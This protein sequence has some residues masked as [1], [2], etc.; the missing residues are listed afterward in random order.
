MS[1]KIIIF[2]MFIFLIGGLVSW[3]LEPEFAD[4]QLAYKQYYPSPLGVY[5]DIYVQGPV[6]G[7]GA[8]AVYS[9]HLVLG[10]RP[11]SAALQKYVFFTPTMRVQGLMELSSTG[12]VFE[13][14]HGHGGNDN[15]AYMTGNLMLCAG[16]NADQE[17]GGPA[18]GLDTVGAPMI[19]FDGVYNNAI[20]SGIRAA[21]DANVI[22]AVETVP[23][24]N[25]PYVGNVFRG[26]RGITYRVPLIRSDLTKNRCYNGYYEAA[27]VQKDTAEN[28]YVPVDGYK[29]YDP[30][31]Y[32]NYPPGN[33][34]LWRVCM[35]HA[36]QQGSLWLDNN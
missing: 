4:D 18:A 33:P 35:R 36:D 10:Q 15:E 32:P 6:S 7:S 17:R 28:Y 29:V 22:F 21:R 26:Y 30:I 19:K 12:I 34:D 25:N 3:A 23:D 16:N 14:A 13:N 27:F 5:K 1:F 11:I 20:T 9:Y 31:K 24:I 2:L 8:D